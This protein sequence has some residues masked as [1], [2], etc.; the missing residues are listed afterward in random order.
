MIT[1]YLNQVISYFSVEHSKKKPRAL[2]KVYCKACQRWY[3][4][5]NYYTHIKRKKHLENEKKLNKN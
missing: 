4:Y 1:D 3:H 2:Q 5:G